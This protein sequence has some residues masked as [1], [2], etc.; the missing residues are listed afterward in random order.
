MRLA[1]LTWPG[2]QQE[3]AVQIT[4]DEGSCAP[5]FG[6]ERLNE[7]DTRSL[8]FDEERLRILQRNRSGEPL[9]GVAPAGIDYRVV[10]LAKIESDAVTEHLPIKGWLAVDEGDGESEHP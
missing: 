6:P 8:I 4:Y 9:L 2:E 7:L 1:S 3:I 5:R 10:D